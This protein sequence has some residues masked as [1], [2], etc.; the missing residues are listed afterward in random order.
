MLIKGKINTLNVLHSF[1]MFWL[2][3]T[4]RS[5]SILCSAK[6]P[7]KRRKRT[8]KIKKKNQCKMSIIENTELHFTFSSFL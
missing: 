6:P 8:K 1:H 3:K 4:H 5:D 7:Q 2:Q